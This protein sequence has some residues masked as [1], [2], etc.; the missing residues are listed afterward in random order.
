MV[1]VNS[2]SVEQSMSIRMAAIG[3]TSDPSR[4]TANVLGRLYETYRHHIVIAPWIVF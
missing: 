4:L 1:E 3:K 2:S